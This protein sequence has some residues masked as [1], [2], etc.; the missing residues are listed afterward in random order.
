MAQI[1]VDT[2]KLK[3]TYG[4]NILK[5]VIVKTHITSLLDNPK[6]LQWLLK[7]KPDFLTELNKISNIN[8]LDD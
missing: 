4:V 6:I 7:H 3:E 2:Q 8:S 1:H 5:L